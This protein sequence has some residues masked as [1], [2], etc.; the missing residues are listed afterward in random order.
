MTKLPIQDLHYAARRFANSAIDHRH[1]H[2]LADAYLLV[3]LPRYPAI[4]SAMT[5]QMN[6]ALRCVLVRSNSCRAG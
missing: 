4:K 6:T 5:R 2:S 1:S 3:N